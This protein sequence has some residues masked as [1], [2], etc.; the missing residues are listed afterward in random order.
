MRSI[1]R[2]AG[3]A[4]VAVALLAGVVAAQNPPRPMLPPPPPV[5]PAQ[6]PVFLGV[7]LQVTQLPTGGFGLLVMDVRPNSPAMVA[8]IRPGDVI[9]SFDTGVGPVVA[10]N[11]AR[12]AQMIQAM[13][14]GQSV[15]LD[16]DT[17][18]GPWG[19]VTVTLD[20]PVVVAAIVA[21][22]PGAAP[23]R[24]LP[25]TL[26]VRAATPRPMGR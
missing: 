14:P 6:P 22:P 15:A 18:Q 23:A 21:G 1:L 17:P 19:L 10:N 16:I 13:Q 2:F 12:F 20:S 9:K 7:S 26:K 3:L 25:P 24:A 11:A 4:L 5:Q 8:D